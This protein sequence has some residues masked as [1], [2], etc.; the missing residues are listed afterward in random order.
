[1]DA[2]SLGE[3]QG[4]DPGAL[5]KPGEVRPASG[6][7]A[8]NGIDALTRQHTL[9]V[10]TGTDRRRKWKA[11]MELFVWA[12]DSEVKSL[13]RHNVRLRIIGDIQ[14]IQLHLPRTYSQIQK[15]LPPIIRV[16]A[17]LN[18]AAITAN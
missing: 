18:I 14:S 4:K 15:R 11:L 2:W 1:M 16:T 12:L 6:L 5:E 9:V 13:H 3:K 17:A 8:N 7:F 10:K